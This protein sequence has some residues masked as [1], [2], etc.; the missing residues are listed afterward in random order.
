MS[1]AEAEEKLF[2]EF[3]RIV[4]ARDPDAWQLLH[5][6]TVKELVRVAAERLAPNPQLKQGSDR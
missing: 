3:T 6:S 1:Q 4:S 2:L 5:V